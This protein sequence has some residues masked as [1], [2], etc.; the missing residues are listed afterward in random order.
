MPYRF[1]S[2]LLELNFP[3]SKV[4]EVSALSPVVPDP[5]FWDPGGPDSY[6]VSPMP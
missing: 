4:Y 1:H 5:A 2:S 3:E 6:M